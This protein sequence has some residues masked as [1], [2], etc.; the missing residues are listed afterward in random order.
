MPQGKKENNK[1]QA[2]DRKQQGVVRKKVRKQ[3]GAASE[4]EE[5]NKVPQAHTQ[6]NAFECPEKN[7]TFTPES[8]SGNRHFPIPSADDPEQ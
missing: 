4:R 6:S 3:Q 2:N 8:P 7:G 1:A 5:N